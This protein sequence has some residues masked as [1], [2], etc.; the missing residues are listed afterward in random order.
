MKET[1]FPNPPEESELV[2]ITKRWGKQVALSPVAEKGLK[3][4]GLCIHTD[5]ANGRTVMCGRLK[6]N[7]IL[8]ECYEAQTKQDP[9]GAR[10][11]LGG[12]ILRAL[13]R[14]IETG[15]VFEDLS[16]DNPCPLALVV[17]QFA[18]AAPAWA[19]VAVCPGYIPPKGQALLHEIEVGVSDEKLTPFVPKKDV[20]KLN[21]DTKML[22]EREAASS[23]R[24]KIRE[25]KKLLRMCDKWLATFKKLKKISPPRYYGRGY[26]SRSR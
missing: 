21:R 11:F 2:I 24:E 20:L 4:G 13:K 12:I 1:D 22:R 14:T 26:G 16:A 6:N 23:R 15:K 10:K 18:K 7:R 9:D 19:G 8:Q 5:P 17:Y 3:D 25:L